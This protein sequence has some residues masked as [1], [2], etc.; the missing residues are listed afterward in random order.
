MEHVRAEPVP[1]GERARIK[2]H[3]GENSQLAGRTQR[4]ILKS[5]VVMEIPIFRFRQE[6]DADHEGD[7]RKHHGIP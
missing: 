3:A 1:D 7:E 5:V 4:F 2:F 6:Q